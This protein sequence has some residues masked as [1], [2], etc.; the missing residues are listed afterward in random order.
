MIKLR[1]EIATKQVYRLIFHI[2]ILAL[3]LV[4]P[5]LLLPADIQN[6]QRKE[7]INRFT[8]RWA[9]TGLVI[10]PIYL[11]NVYYLIPKFLIP[12]K[13]VAYAGILILG[14]IVTVLINGQIHLLALSPEFLVPGGRVP[15]GG[16]ATR[17]IL[18]PL[19]MSLALGTSFEMIINW[20]IQRREKAQIEREKMAAE[21]SFLKSQM[22][23]HFLFN[24][25][26]NI[27][28]L[29][30]QRSDK[31]GEAVLML[32]SLMRYMLYGSNNGRTQLSKE[33]ECIENYIAIQKMRIS[34]SEEIRIAF[35]VSGGTVN[36]KI[37]PLILLP[38]VEN[39]FKHG[40]SYNQRSEVL[41]D[42]DVNRNVLDLNVRNTKRLDA[43]SKKLTENESGIGL[44]NI[45]R[46]LEL[47]YP[48]KHELSIQDG[49]D[50]F[51]ARLRIEL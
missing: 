15:G 14:A 51:E 46:R 23:P 16:S 36:S 50:Y 32:S 8:I 31:T 40:V 5:F 29:A 42:I 48:G 30:E 22:N 13:Y 34:T 38:F 43:T 12:G 10:V 18:F 3:L 41:I 19:T 35:K 33:I 20:E 9:T 2:L 17:I 37:E 6:F 1:T 25:L 28:A 26:N 24:S 21:L 49:K 11:V 47:L 39:A 7:L 44:N 4:I 45:K 27:Y